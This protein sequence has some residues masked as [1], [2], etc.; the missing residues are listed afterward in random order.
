MLRKVLLAVAN[1][2]SFHNGYSEGWVTNGIVAYFP[3]PLIIRYLVKS[4]RQA[5]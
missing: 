5:E 4:I 3:F 2:T 1:L